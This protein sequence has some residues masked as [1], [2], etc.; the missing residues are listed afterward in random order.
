MS[1]ES[2]LSRVSRIL[3]LTG[4]IFGEYPGSAVD[5]VHGGPP[6]PHS[7]RTGSVKAEVVLSAGSGTPNDAR[8][9]MV[10]LT[11]A[12]RIVNS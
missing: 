5:P 12:V 7:A 11:G 3:V 9:I 2:C 4:R 10:I 8:G 6:S 1:Q